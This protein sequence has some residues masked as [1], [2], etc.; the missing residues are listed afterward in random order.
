MRLVRDTSWKRTR[1][2]APAPT[3]LTLVEVLASLSILC[4]IVITGGALCRSIVTN[5]AAE[6]ARHRWTR[7]ASAL[8]DSIALDVLQGDFDP[9]GDRARADPRVRVEGQSPDLALSIRTRDSGPVHRRY[10]LDRGRLRTTTGSLASGSPADQAAA[11]STALDGVVRFE[12]ALDPSG[13]RLRVRIHGP[14]GLI[15]ER[16]YTL[17]PGSAP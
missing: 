4:L 16:S 12:P 11:W 5:A 14:A 10:A 15:A 17:E 7:A 3:G 2:R 13:S 9:V 6:S 1:P 8:L